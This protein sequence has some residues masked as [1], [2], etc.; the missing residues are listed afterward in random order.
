MLKDYLK[1]RNLSLYHLAK[2]SAVPYSTVNDL[3]NNRVFAENCKAGVIRRIAAALQ[4]SMEELLNICDET[5]PVE[6][7]HGSVN[8]RIFARNKIYYVEFS[9]DGKTY[10][11]ELCSLNRDC[12][13]FVNDFAAWEIDDLIS[14]KELEVVMDELSHHA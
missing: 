11:K 6:T 4:I 2:V 3:A 12:A 14:R 1:K 13:F 10:K 7:D 8:A 9:Y 5:T